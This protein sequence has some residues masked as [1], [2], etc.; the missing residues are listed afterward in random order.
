MSAQE[1]AHANMEMWAKRI[2]GQRESSSDEKLLQTSRTH[3]YGMNER[4]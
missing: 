2:G 4:R 3:F 1:R